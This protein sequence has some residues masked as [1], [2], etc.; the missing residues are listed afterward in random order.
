MPDPAPSPVPYRAPWWLPSGHLQTLWAYFRGGRPVDLRW[1]RW[2]R[3]DGDFNDLAWLDGPPDAPLVVLFHGLEGSARSHY[4]LH[5]LRALKV[6]GWRGVVAHFRG[7][8]G[9]PNRLPR[10]YHAGDSAE[11]A[12]FMAHLQPKAQ[13]AP[14]YAVGVSLGGNA[15]LKWLGEYGPRAR[16]YVQRAAAVSAPM[17]MPA[18]G[19][20]LDRGLNRLYAWHFLASLKAKIRQKRIAH[21]GHLGHLDLTGIWSLRAFDDRVTAPLHGYLG[22]EDYWQ[23]SAARPWLKHIAIP[24]LILNARND[25][26]VPAA[27]LPGQAEVSPQ[28]TL[29]YP[30]DGGHAG[31]PSSPFPGCMDWLPRRLLAFL[32]G[33]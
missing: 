28:V 17:D 24:T 10:A 8:S 22:V 18:A 5:L 25:P 13:P 6:R 1:E 12:A 14:L 15:L 27:S 32:G 16:S 26:M 21:I 31:F 20:A 33:A 2:E 3:S 7:C 11:I 4:A 30:E 19:H 23:R 29:E 9:E